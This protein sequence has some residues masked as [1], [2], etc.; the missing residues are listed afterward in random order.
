MFRGL[1]NDAKSA[2]GSVLSRYAVRASVAV[3]FLIA[4]GFATTAVTLMLVERFGAIAAY[5]FVAAA[6]AAIGFIA[7]IAVAA[8][9]EEEKVAEAEEES[10]DTSAL[11]SDAASQAAVQLPLA[12]LGTLLTTPA[13]PTSVMA[14]TRALGRNLPLVLLLGLVALLFW[15]SELGEEAA[16][17]QEPSDTTANDAAHASS[18]NEIEREAA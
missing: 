8:K 7:A 9:E 12:F 16:S 1:I 6:F 15:P 5:W 4:L 18:E 3:P 17:D 11:A 10:A 2:A 14:L 13:G